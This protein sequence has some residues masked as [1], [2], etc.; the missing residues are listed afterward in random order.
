M[1]R[2]SPP[3]GWAAGAAGRAGPPAW[4]G[5][6]WAR[7]WVV[8]LFAVT[9]AG[10]F[11][12][13]LFPADG[14][15]W[16]HLASGRWIAVHH[17]LP[18][19]AFFSVLPAARGWADYYW[20]FQLLV[21]ALH[22][23]GGYVALVA[24]RG[25]LLLALAAVLLVHL[26]RSAT[27]IGSAFGGGQAVVWTLAL[28]A[29][30]PRFG[31]L[32]P[33]LVS[34]LLLASLLLLLEHFPRALPLAPLLGLTWANVHGIEYPVVLLALGAWGAPLVLRQLRARA[35]PAG[36]QRRRLAWLSVTALTPLATP[37][38]WCL[39]PMPFASVRFVS[40]AISEMRPFDPAQL[41]LR[42]EHGGITADS[43][44]TALLVL[45]AAALLDRAVRRALPLPHLLLA[46]GGALL[47]L[48]G[49]RFAL[50]LTL[51]VVPLLAGWR[52]PPPA[53]SVALRRIAAA[54]LALAALLGVHHRLAGHRRWPLD[55]AALPGGIS[56][57]LARAGGGGVLLAYPDLAGWFEWTLYPRYRVLS[58]LQAY[59]FDDQSLYLTSAAFAD[60]Q[61]LATVLD[62][63]RPAWVAAPLAAPR[64]R[65]LLESVGGY[66]P[67]VFDGAMVLYGRHAGQE[68]LVDRW[69]LRAV[70]PYAPAA[71]LAVARRD[72][73]A[74]ELAQLHALDPQNAFVAV[75]LA[76]LRLDQRQPQA[77][78]R[79]ATPATVAAPALP[80]AW[81]VRGEALA[82]GRRYGEA[83]AA[84]QEAAARGT[85][86]AAVGRLAWAA[87]MRLGQPARA[88][89]ALAPVL[90]PLA[91]DTTWTDLWG[92]AESA[93]AS[94]DLASAERLLRFAWWK[95]PSGP[96]RARLEAALAALPAA[97]EAHIRSLAPR[98]PLGAGPSAGP[99]AT[100]HGAPAA[101]P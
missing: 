52:A 37:N 43:A 47:L 57:F 4:H 79:L 11:A 99:R 30:L 35:F 69:A 46:A 71:P 3:W 15:L 36:E 32:R 51:L 62:R 93:R 84:Y 28:L 87:W 94:G 100:P 22:R 42:L 77:A 10:V 21:F 12:W 27:A 67:V 58:D 59:L 38:G 40:Q 5:A 26:R 53:V 80:E 56:R 29:L 101:P 85:P 8:L 39:L 2:D 92:L 17:A 88:Y 60:R 63:W 49:A 73:A 54:A 89:E 68:A 81:L 86:P 34:L 91:G 6:P 76:R 18:R 9:A 82:A 44:F 23:L 33:H 45:A 20:L 13:P 65:P 66:E 90:S 24:L 83:L 78:L 31:S 72:V 41:G 50:E 95:A 74:H 64:F 96:A 75:A 1:T 48:R 97:A 7:L 55:E 98:P 14:D 16:Y 70:D 61:V 25:T 19:T